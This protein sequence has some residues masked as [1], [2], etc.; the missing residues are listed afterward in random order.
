MLKVGCAGFPVGRDRYWRGLSF[1]EALTGE[2]MPRPETLAA[3]RADA[4][5]GAEFGVQAFRFITHGPQDRGFPAAGKKLTPSRRGFCGGFRDSL[6]VHE[7]W[8]STRAAAEALGARLI[9]FETPENFQPGP[10]RLRDMYRFFK[11]IPR[12]KWSL[13][14]GPRGAAWESDL[15]DRV[16]ADLGLVR[17]FDPLRERP[18]ERGAFLCLRP[19]GPRAGA[20]SVDSMSTICEAARGR[21]AYAVLTHRQAFA[22]AERLVRKAEE[23]LRIS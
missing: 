23:S 5:A 10:D 3:W 8:L 6:E 11:S 16:S 17:A 18:P 2:H 14:W 12:G 20:L 4:P 22:D 7:A 9:F 13:V 19:R 21:P 1:S 15:K